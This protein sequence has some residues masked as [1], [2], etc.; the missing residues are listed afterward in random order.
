MHV[1][2]AMLTLHVYGRTR[3]TALLSKSNHVAGTIKFLATVSVERLSGFISDMKQENPDRWVDLHIRSA[4]DDGMNYIAFH[5]ILPD[6]RKKTHTKAVNRLLQYL[7]D[8]LG[9][10]PE[11]HGHEDPVP[12]GVKGWSISTVKVVI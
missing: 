10:R 2:P 11:T 5:Y 6:G 9:T 1:H 4:G 8:Q 12:V 7:R 3:M